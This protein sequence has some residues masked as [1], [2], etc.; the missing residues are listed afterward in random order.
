VLEPAEL[1]DAVAAEA[2]AMLDGSRFRRA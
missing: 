2:R 1:S